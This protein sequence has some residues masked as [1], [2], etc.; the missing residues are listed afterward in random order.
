MGW[1]LAVF[2]F[3]YSVGSTFL[4]VRAARRVLQFDAVFQTII[5]PMQLYA[6]TLRRITTAEGLLH[7][8]PEV[9][10]FHKANMELLFQIDRAL[11]AV[12]QGRPQQEKRPKHL[13][14]PEVV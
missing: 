1:A 12:K 7:D 8:H 5:D 13:P 2:L 6:D 14:R 3:L 10:A 9:L 4:L 11:E